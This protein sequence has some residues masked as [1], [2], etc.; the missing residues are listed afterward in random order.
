MFYCLLMQ[1]QE[2][3]DCQKLFCSFRLQSCR[4]F[5]TNQM[6]KSVLPCLATTTFWSFK[7]RS[8]TLNTVHHMNSHHEPSPLL[9]FTQQK[10]LFSHQ[11]LKNPASTHPEEL[12]FSQLFI[13]PTSSCYSNAIT[14]DDRSALSAAICW[15]ELRTRED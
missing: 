14:I 5:H 8:S 12:D 7:K 4:I 11:T 9:L 15:N 3:W 6:K 1:M 13:K 2:Q 10:M